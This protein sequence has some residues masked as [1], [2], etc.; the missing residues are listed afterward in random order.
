M[1]RCLPKPISGGFTLIELVVAISLIGIA[2]LGVTYSLQFS[3]RYSAD[4][5]WQTKTL[6]L[7]TAY[8]EE[9]LAQ[10]F[11]E[12]SPAQALT[13]CQPC[14]PESRFGADNER[15]GKSLNQFD[16]VDDY[17][18]VNEQTL[19]ILGEPR[20]GYANYHVAINVSYAGHE[21]GLQKPQSAKRIDLTITPPGQK[22]QQFVFYRGN[23]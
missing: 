22:A 14:T 18:G 11:D 10:A 5:L 2:L 23:H 9:I 17:H 8:R 16:D 19:N 21:L 6:S 1:A 12:T 4:P 7:A 13:P 20:E 15:R 3:V